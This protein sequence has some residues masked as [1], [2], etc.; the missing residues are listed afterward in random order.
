VSDKNAIVTEL[1]NS[2]EFND[3]INKMEPA[4]LRDDLKSEIVLILME[5]EEAKLIGLHQ[6]KELKFFTVRI[7]LNQIQ[8]KS[9]PFYK[10][11]RVP[12]VELNG[13]E[14][15]DEYNHEDREIKELM[16]DVAIEEI[17]RLHWYN[18]ELLRL[19]IQHGNFRAIEKLTRIPFVSCYKNIKSS[20]KMLKQKAEEAKPMFT[21]AEMSFIQNGGRCRA[22]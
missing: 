10:K 12:V 4:H 13:Y 9:S 16:E 5:T 15:A 6:R 11:F 7:I 18:A 19:Y 1:Y 8:S 22:I 17:D 3:C 20:L 14:T 2:R 21:K